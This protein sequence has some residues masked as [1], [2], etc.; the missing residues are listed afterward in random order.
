M[1]NYTNLPWL[2]VSFIMPLS[3]NNA[4]CWHKPPHIPECTHISPFCGRRN[5]YIWH[6]VTVM[7]RCPCA[8]LT[9]HVLATIGIVYYSAA[10]L[11]FVLN[12]TWLFL[13]FF[14][15][16]HTNIK[17]VRSLKL[18]IL[19]VHYHFGKIWKETLRFLNDFTW[20]T[21]SLIHTLQLKSLVWARHT[22]FEKRTSF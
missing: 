16:L 7:G 6:Y 22:V 17:H 19:N 20:S 2:D 14:A 9:R 1:Q 11:W 10:H 15:R 18:G 21:V 8:A 5:F 4:I 13:A 3:T 12:K